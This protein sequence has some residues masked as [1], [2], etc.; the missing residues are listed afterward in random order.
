MF[1]HINPAKP[2]VSIITLMLA[3]FTLAL[4][5]LAFETYYSKTK[6][7]YISKGVLY[8]ESRRI[9]DMGLLDVIVLRIPANDPNLLL[10]A[11]ASSDPGYKETASTLLTGTGAIAGVNGDY[12][13][14]AG[15]YSMPMGLQVDTNGVLSVSNNANT[16][17]NKYSSFMLADDGKYFMGHVNATVRFFNNGAE[18]IILGSMNKVADLGGPSAITRDFME[19]TA[20]I[21]ARIEGAVKIQVVGNYITKISAK[22]ETVEV[23]ADGYVIIMSSAAA[24]ECLRAFAVGQYAELIVDSWLDLNAIKAAISGG[25]LILAGGVPVSQGEQFIT[26]VHPRTAIGL[27]ADGSEIILMVVDGRSHSVGV[28]HSELGQLMLEAGAATAMHLDGG[29]SSEM[30]ITKPGY[31]G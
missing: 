20:A 12:F 10:S 13:G 18:N 8:E 1:K 7:E 17:A 22:G 28:K 26:G 6:S 5:T 23:P 14:T 25:G 9:T 16:G 15:S 2:A 27:T 4:P 21:D 3:L 24:D 31:D 19:T 30:L 29:G 11:A